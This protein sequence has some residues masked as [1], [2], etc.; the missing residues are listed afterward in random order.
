MHEFSIAMNIVDIASEY[1]RK[2]EAVTVQEIEIEVGQLA[3]I[4]IDALE[5]SLESAVKGTI[6]EKAKRTII[7]LPGLVRC[8]VCRHEFESSDFFTECPKC[9]AGPPEIIQ[10][11]E[12]RVK[13]LIID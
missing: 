11:R 12:L 3:G 9:G 10:G 2:E 7:S 13:S 4:V 6:L 8:T 1:A 5:L